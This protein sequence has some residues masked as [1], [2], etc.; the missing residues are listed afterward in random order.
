MAPKRS[1]PPRDQR[2]PLYLSKDEKKKLGEI[3][4]DAHMPSWASTFR[5]LLLTEYDRRFPKPSFTN[6]KAE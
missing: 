5:F 4:K 1:N 2:L 3:M 6:A